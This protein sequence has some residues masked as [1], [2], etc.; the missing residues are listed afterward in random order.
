ML[1]MEYLG[2]SDGAQDEELVCI[3]EN[4]ACGVDGIQVVTGCTPEKET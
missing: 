3:S 1:A 4:R 2:L